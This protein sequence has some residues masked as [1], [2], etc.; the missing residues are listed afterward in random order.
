MT[1]G[2]DEVSV[3]K[4]ALY[5]R[6]LIAKAT[7]S[8]LSKIAAKSVYRD[9]TVRNWNTTTKLLALATSAA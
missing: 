2:V 6:R 4:H 5:F 8:K 7:R 1:P 9:L 3:G